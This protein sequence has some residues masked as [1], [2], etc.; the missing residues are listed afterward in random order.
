V[1]EE[2]IKRRNLRLRCLVIDPIRRLAPLVLSPGTK[3]K[4]VAY[5]P[6]ILKALHIDQFPTQQF[7]REL[8]FA[9]DQLARRGPP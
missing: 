5:L 9:I 1:A 2:T 8:A 4:I 6:A 3:A 7:V